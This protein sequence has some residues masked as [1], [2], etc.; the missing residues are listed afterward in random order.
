MSILDEFKNTHPETI[1]QRMGQYIGQT[2]KHIN[3]I[4]NCMELTLEQKQDICEYIE[5]MDAFFNYVCPLIEPIAYCKIDNVKL[6]RKDYYERF[7]QIITTL[8][9]HTERE[10]SRTQSR[11]REAETSN[12][13]RDELLKE[14][15]QMENNFRHPYQ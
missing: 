4:K 13:E 1:V 10:I 7:K 12:H 15:N 9:S 14:L 5:N 8:H 3:A 6:I 2:N 11:Q